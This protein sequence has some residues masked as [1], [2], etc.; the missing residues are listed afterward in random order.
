MGYI[1]VNETQES[2]LSKQHQVKINRS[3]IR[4]KT[5]IDEENKR[6]LAHATGSSHCRSGE[7]Q[8]DAALTPLMERLFPQVNL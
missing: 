3:D 6:Q 7:G 5:K 8:M 4:V 2:F 1:Q